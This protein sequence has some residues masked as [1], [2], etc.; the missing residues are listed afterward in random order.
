MIR[1]TL[2]AAAAVTLALPAVAIGDSQPSP[3][4]LAAK[5]CKSEQAQAAATF[6]L[7]YGTNA[8]KSNAFGRCVAKHQATAQDEVQNA[9][10]QCRAEQQADATAF[11]KKYGSNTQAKGKGAGS[12]AFGKCVSAKALAA[13][14]N[15]ANADVAAAKLCKTELAAGT[16]AF[17]TKYGTGTAKRN[18]FGKCVST[19]SQAIH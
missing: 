17:A 9:A 7:T 5:T 8:S 19:K 10:K 18:A 12:D 15:D 1:Q 13:A 3:T 4:A 11:A 2:V 16:A 14:Q 6:K